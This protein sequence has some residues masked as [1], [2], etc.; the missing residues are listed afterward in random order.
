MP[1]HDSHEHPVVVPGFRRFKGHSG[2]IP[3]H[4]YACVVLHLR[5]RVVG[6][7][8]LEAQQSIGTCMHGYLQLQPSTW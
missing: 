6:S 1:L 5:M 3:I 7:T 8:G 2:V 4:A